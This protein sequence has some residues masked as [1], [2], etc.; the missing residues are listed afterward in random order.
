VNANKKNCFNFKEYILEVN[1]N[2][3][4]WSGSRTLAIPYDISE[5][6]LMKI[7]P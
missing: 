4:K 2:F 3:I 1:D 7:L 5:D 6:E